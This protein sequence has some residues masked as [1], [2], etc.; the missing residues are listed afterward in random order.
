MTIR[1][2]SYIHSV[3]I[4]ACGGLASAHATSINVPVHPHA[5]SQRVSSNDNEQSIRNEELAVVQELRTRVQQG[6]A[7]AM[8]GLG[9]MYALGRGVGKNYGTALD[10]F[11]RAAL[12]GQV[13]GMVNV[14]LLYD[15][16]TNL[17]GHSISAYAWLRA[18]LS[19]GVPDED[20]DAII[21]R[22]GMIAS[23]IGETNAARAECLASLLIEDIGERVGYPKSQS[24]ESA[25][26]WGSERSTESTARNHVR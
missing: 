15:R 20:R 13:P 25:S 3:I 23:R 2:H 7:A 1:G 9:M 11:R 26:N 17:P 8:N 24:T 4:C 14:G 12:Q 5:H 22:L 10:L 19:F 16:H 6:D 18:A 21:F